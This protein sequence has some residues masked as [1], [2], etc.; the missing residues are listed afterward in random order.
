[1][2]ELIR[3]SFIYIQN[4]ERDLLI[5]SRP[6]SV[7]SALMTTG[8]SE[9]NFHQ[10]DPLRTLQFLTLELSSKLKKILPDDKNIH[11]ILYE[12]KHTIRRFDSSSMGSCRSS[13]SVVFQVCSFSL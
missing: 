7:S 11:K 6:T 5:S 10:F 8:K 2:L 3:K 4:T 9:V 12:I 1:M 13:P